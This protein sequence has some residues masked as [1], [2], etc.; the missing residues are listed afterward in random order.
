MDSEYFINSLKSK[1]EDQNG[2]AEY[3]KRKWSKGR[4]HR[5]AFTLF[6]LIPR[7]QFS[8]F[9]SKVCQID[10]I[11]SIYL[12]LL[13]QCGHLIL[14]NVLLQ[15]WLRKT[16]TT[17]VLHLLSFQYLSTFG[18]SKLVFYFDSRVKMMYKEDP[19]LLFLKIGVF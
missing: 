4:N 7:Y 17:Q 14:K 2:K 11:I 9:T 19:A 8:V 3:L 15:I 16:L 6:L 18:C 1:G 5:A 13:A 10:F 12:P